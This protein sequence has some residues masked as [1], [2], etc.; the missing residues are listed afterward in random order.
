MKDKVM[1][2]IKLVYWVLSNGLRKGEFGLK[3]NNKIMSSLIFGLIF[4]CVIFVM[5]Y[6]LFFNVRDYWN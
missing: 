4:F 3:D 5:W 2:I 6:K 1:S